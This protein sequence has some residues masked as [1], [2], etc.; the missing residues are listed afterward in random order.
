MDSRPEINEFNLTMIRIISA[1]VGN[2]RILNG[3]VAPAAGAAP[4]DVHVPNF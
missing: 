3:I 1:C 2:I 4:P